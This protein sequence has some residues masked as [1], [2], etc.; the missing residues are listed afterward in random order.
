M[1]Q[2]ARHYSGKFVLSVEIPHS[3]LTFCPTTAKSNCSGLFLCI[4]QSF[5]V[6]GTAVTHFSLIYLSL[7]I[8]LLLSLPERLVVQV[9][10]PA[11]T[12]LIQVL[13]A[14]VAM[15]ASI[16][17]FRSNQPNQL[18]GQRSVGCKSNAVYERVDT[19][20]FP[21]AHRAAYLLSGLSCA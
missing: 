8:T 14:A 11:N 20:L 4:R 16:G 3:P 2:K 6:D 1:K 15:A 9:H 5:S 10:L 21:S 7:S 17:L 18:L 13:S 19:S 12:N